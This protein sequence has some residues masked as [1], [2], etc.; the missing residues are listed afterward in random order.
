MLKAFIVTSQRGEIASAFES[1]P[2]GDQG[3]FTNAVKHSQFLRV[4]SASNA[5]LPLTTIVAEAISKNMTFHLKKSLQKVFFERENFT[6]D[7]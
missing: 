1:L 5:A 7:N 4:A 2:L 6:N 3:T